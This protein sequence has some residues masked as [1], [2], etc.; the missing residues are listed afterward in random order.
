MPDKTSG[1]EDRL[2]R[3]NYAKRANGRTLRMPEPS[4]AK[5]ADGRTL[6]E[7]VPSLAKRKTLKYR[8]RK[9]NFN[10]WGG[11]LNED[12]QTIRKGQISALAFSLITNCRVSVWSEEELKPLKKRFKQLIDEI[13]IKPTL[14][15]IRD[16]IDKDIN[17]LP[18]GTECPTG[19]EILNYVDERIRAIS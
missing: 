1:Q 10:L 13:P 14:E 19:T 17:N 4:L 12:N 15:F 8:P 5:R 9:N 11:A 16:K 6:P 18:E 2:K 3:K 7:P